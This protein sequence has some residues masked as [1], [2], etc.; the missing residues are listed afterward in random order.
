L[1]TT[2]G[3]G[4]GIQAK[5]FGQH[6]I[7]AVSQL[8][9]LQPSEEAPL[10]LIEQAVEKEDGRLEFIRGYPQ[11]GGVSR[12]RNRLRG[13]PSAKL[14]ASLLAIGGSVKEP[15][16][17]LRAAQTSRSHQIVEGIL[18]LSMECIGEFVSK[19]AT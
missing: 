17:H 10:L 12:Q 2:A 14:I 13:L 19:P 4:M 1:L 8:H 11:G 9:R 5:K 16:G 18:D 3:N 15:S 6:T 7:A